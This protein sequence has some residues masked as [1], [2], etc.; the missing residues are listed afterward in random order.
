[1]ALYV[2]VDLFVF[3]GGI[4]TAGDAAQQFLIG[5]VGAYVG[6]CLSNLLWDTSFR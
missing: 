5:T 6:I 3:H 2:T 4:R 1:M